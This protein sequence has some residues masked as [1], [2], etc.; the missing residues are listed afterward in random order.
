LKTPVCVSLHILLSGIPPVAHARGPQLDIEA[1]L[2]SPH[3]KSK[4]RRAV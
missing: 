1:L 3:M 2:Y 4:L